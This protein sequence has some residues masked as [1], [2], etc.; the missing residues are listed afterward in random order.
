MKTF[1]LIL[2]TIVSLALAGPVDLIQNT[3][4][5]NGQYKCT[6]GDID[7]WMTPGV[8]SEEDGFVVYWLMPFTFALKN[9]G[10]ESITIPLTSFYMKD[11]TGFS[12]DFLKRDDAASIVRGNVKSGAGSWSNAWATALV[13]EADAKKIMKED[14]EKALIALTKVPENSILLRAGEKK[15]VMMVTPVLPEKATSFTV[16]FAPEQGQPAEIVFSKLQPINGEK[17][18]KTKQVAG[19]CCSDTKQGAKVPYDTGNKTAKAW[20]FKPNDMITVVSVNGTDNDIN[21][22]NQLEA[23]LRSAPENSKF[24]FKVMRNKQ[25]LTLA[26]PEKVEDTS[27]TVA[28]PVESTDSKT[29][30][31]STPQKTMT[32]TDFGG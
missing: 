14:S 2:L 26:L 9:N 4:P 10:K 5:T 24:T 15:L 3:V 30:T 16:V 23:I 17:Y 7:V 22:R 21:S 28:E 29:D 1:C 11:D 27:S 20:G 32:N 12:V 25:P 18:C 8:A 19:F 31:S 6:S 13:G